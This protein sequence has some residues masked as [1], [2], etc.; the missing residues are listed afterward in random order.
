MTNREVISC[1]FLSQIT[2][3]YQPK[4]SILRLFELGGA[5][6]LVVSFIRTT[7]TQAI[8]AETFR[9]WEKRHFI[10]TKKTLIEP[11]LPVST[12]MPFSHRLE[13]IQI[14][15]LTEAKKKD[16]VEHVLNLIRRIDPNHRFISDKPKSVSHH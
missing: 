10:H 5:W 16:T 8:D 12:I 13:P 4:E 3:S 2:E 9:L 1:T 6:V 14:K 15:Q 11:V 7:E